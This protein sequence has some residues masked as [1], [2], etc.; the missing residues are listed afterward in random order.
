MQNPDER[1]FTLWNQQRASFY[2]RCKKFLYRK[3]EKDKEK[4]IDTEGDET[5][6]EN[7]VQDAIESFLCV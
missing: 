3:S 4:R 1:P 2:N 6:N 7:F 5:R